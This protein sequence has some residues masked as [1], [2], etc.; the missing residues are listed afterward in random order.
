MGNKYARQL[1]TCQPNPLHS[2]FDV[3]TSPACLTAFSCREIRY[4]VKT[5]VGSD[6]IIIQNTNGLYGSQTFYKRGDLLTLGR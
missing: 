6:E 4:K 3:I 2:P 5:G 1:R